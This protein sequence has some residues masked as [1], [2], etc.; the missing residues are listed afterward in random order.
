MNRFTKFTLISLFSV[1]ATHAQDAPQPAGPA[2]TP[3]A[4]PAQTTPRER[5][6]SNRRFDPAMF[7]MTPDQRAK[8]E[9]A[10]AAYRG[11]ITPLEDRLRAA[12]RELEEAINADKLDEAN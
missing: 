6:Y 9:E 11:V 12:R 4:S 2:A 5:P 8:M 7:E 3:P 1:F 10:N